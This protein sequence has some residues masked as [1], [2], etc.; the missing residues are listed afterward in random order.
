MTWWP[1]W[2]AAT[3]NSSRAKAQPREFHTEQGCP[4]APLSPLP[5]Q[6]RL[7]GPLLNLRALPSCPAT[8]CVPAGARASMSHIHPF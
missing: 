7:H 2:E 4:G 8:W 3:H 6:V 5:F 1:H